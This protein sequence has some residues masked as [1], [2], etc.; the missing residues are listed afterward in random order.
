MKNID[1]NPWYNGEYDDIDFRK[2]I[3]R[4]GNP[5]IMQVGREII[6]W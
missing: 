6:K 5:D 3:E 2:E 4:V 1:T